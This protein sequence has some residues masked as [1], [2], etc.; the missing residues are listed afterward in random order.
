MPQN[1]EH[2]PN[3]WLKA[4]MNY[5]KLTLNR[6]FGVPYIFLL[7]GLMVNQLSRF[8]SASS[9]LVIRALIC[10]NKSS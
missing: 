4:T 3:L 10:S 1:Q 7:A 5:G 6:A 9:K 2:A 8:A